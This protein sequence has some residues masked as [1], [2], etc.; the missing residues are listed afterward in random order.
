MEGHSLAV[1]V[2]Q[3]RREIA[4]SLNAAG[5]M[6]TVA[7][8]ITLYLYPPRFAPAYTESGE[9]KLTLVHP[10]TRARRAYPK[11]QAPYPRLRPL[12]FI[13]RVPA[14]PAAPPFVAPSLTPP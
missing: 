13:P 7:A 5:L 6:L 4:W 2:R 14:H 9:H 11:H 1:L 8:A 12:P 10:P 3:Y